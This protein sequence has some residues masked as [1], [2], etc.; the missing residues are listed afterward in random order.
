MMTKTIGTNIFAP[1]LTLYL[2]QRL[3][4][5]LANHCQVMIP[6]ARALVFSQTMHQGLSQ[7]GSGAA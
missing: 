2:G 7:N 1:Y 4:K 3:R 6:R 5:A